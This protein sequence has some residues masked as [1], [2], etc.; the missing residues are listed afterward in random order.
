MIGMEERAADVSL[1]NLLVKVD[2]VKFHDAFYEFY[3]DL[4]WRTAPLGG[5]FLDSWIKAVEKY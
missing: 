5:W 4:S 1:G 2:G 3:V